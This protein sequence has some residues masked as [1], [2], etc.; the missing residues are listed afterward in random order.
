MVKKTLIIALLFLSIGQYSAMAAHVYLD[1]GRVCTGCKV[2]V[3]NG[4]VVGITDKKGNSFS[5]REGQTMRIIKHPFLGAALQ[6]AGQGMQNAAQNYQPP[7]QT[8]CTSNGYGSTVTTN[9][10][11]Y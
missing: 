5:F 10:T 9:C 3:E 6:G 8:Y 11:S 2:T 4:Y 1:D 7:R